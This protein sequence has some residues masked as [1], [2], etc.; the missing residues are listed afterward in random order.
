MAD[1][2][3]RLVWFAVVA[4]A[5]FFSIFAVLGNFVTVNAENSGPVAIHDSVSPGIHHINGILMLPLSCD[6]LSVGVEQVSA[7]QY[8]LAFTTWQDPSIV[9]PAEP[10]PR[11]FETVAFASASGTTFIAT[12]DGKPLPIFIVRDAAAS[13]TP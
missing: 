3:R 7:S 2:I 11:A 1:T 8:M 13:S 12:L 10:T 4:T 9:C 6:E 5:A